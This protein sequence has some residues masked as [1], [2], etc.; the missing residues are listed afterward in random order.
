M[1]IS[2]RNIMQLIF[3]FIVL[4]TICA[5]FYTSTTGTKTN[6]AKKYALLIG[7]GTKESDNYESFYNNI[8]YVANAL[9]KMGYDDEDV[10]ILFFGGKTSFR[11]VVEGDATKEHFVYELNR[12]SNIIDD[13]DALLIFRSGHGMLELIF[14]ENDQFPNYDNAHNAANLKFSNP[15][16]VMNFPDGKLGC[17]EFQELLE[18][19]EARQ[20]VVILNQC[21]CGQFADIAVNLPKAVVVTQT[22]EVEHG[23]HQTRKTM[24]WKHKEWPFVKCFFDGFLQTDKKAEKQSVLD[25]FRYMLKCNPNIEG[26]GIQAD[27]PLLKEH[28]KITYGNELAIGAVYIH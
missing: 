4:N 10:K 24:M 12:F 26:V 22:K 25:A 19:I 21:F 20:I 28:P 14:E 9:K 3:L 2:T 13:N 1:I 16:A 5:C 6:E 18:R 17:F 27:R 15:E 7:G 23:F 11:P 8:D